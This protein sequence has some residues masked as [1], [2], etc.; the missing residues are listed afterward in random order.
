MKNIIKNLSLI[1][2]LTFAFVIVSCDK[3]PITT[4]V[5]FENDEIELKIDS[6]LTAG[7]FEFEGDTIEVDVDKLVADA[8]SSA[9][10]IKSTELTKIAIKVIAPAGA[11]LDNIDAITLKIK[12]EGLGTVDLGSI[13]TIPKTG[14]KEIEIPV[15]TS[16][17]V[18][19]YLDKKLLI[20]DGSATVGT[21]IEETICI[22]VIL[23]FVAEVEVL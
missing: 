21:A 9:D 20:I 4:N 18:E 15:N 6:G 12:A 2:I 16:F 10:K 13:G 7:V 23:S 17:D 3:V 8:E 14:L 11:S 5:D 1:A 19:K 22:K